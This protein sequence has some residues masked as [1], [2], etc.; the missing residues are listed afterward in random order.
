MGLSTCRHRGRLSGAENM[1][2]ATPRNRG[3][4]ANRSLVL[5]PLRPHIILQRALQGD[6]YPTQVM[7]PGELSVLQSRRLVVHATG[8]M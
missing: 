7:H 2:P 6:V 3:S 8:R 5:R 1:F 4:P